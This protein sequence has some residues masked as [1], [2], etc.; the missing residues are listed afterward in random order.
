MFLLFSILYK[1][2]LHISFLLLNISYSTLFAELFSQEG[3]DDSDFKEWWTIQVL[4]NVNG[5]LIVAADSGT[6]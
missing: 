6:M 4:K 3:F 5:V 1:K 2:I